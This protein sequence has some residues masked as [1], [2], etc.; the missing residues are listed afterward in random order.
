[1][2]K[3]TKYDENGQYPDVSYKG[4]VCTSSGCYSYFD[5]SFTFNFIFDPFSGTFG[6]KWRRAEN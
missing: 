6:E 5:P 3:M 1:M 4:A 2:T